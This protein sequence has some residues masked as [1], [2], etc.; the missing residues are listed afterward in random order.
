MQYLIFQ[1]GAGLGLT[2]MV[3]SK[4]LDLKKYYLQEWP[5]QATTEFLFET[6][7]NFYGSNIECEIING[8]WGDLELNLRIEEIEKIDCALLADC[9]YCK[10]N[11]PNLLNTLDCIITKF[12]VPVLCIFHLRK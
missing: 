8:F 7:R 6:I 11:F 1:L 4:V 12:S 3:A 10:E 5:D 2:S 9:F